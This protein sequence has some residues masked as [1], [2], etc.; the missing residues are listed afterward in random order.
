[1]ILGVSRVVEFLLRIYPR[2]RDFS[3]IYVPRMRSINSN[4]FRDTLRSV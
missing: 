2:P 1:M 3:R 4:E